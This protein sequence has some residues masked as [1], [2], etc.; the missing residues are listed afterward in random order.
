MISSD[1][2]LALLRVSA[3]VI[4]AILKFALWS[5]Q[6]SKGSCQIISK[7]VRTCCNLVQMILCF[8][9]IRLFI[10]SRSSNGRCTSWTSAFSCLNFFFSFVGSCQGWGGSGSGSGEDQ[11]DPVGSVRV[12]VLDFCVVIPELLLFFRCKIMQQ[13]LCIKNPY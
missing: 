10:I 9:R 12:S 2:M 1:L 5:F 3:H 4:L 8:G 13:V 11:V 7:G 6:L